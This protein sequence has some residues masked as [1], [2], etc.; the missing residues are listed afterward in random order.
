VALF[1]SIDVQAKLDLFLSVSARDDH[2]SGVSCRH[3][4]L[5]KDV[6]D[7]IHALGLQVVAWTVDDP[8]RAEELARMGVDGIT[9]HRVS[10]MRELL[11]AP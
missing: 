2:P 10:A 9:T 3:T 6:I 1:Y 11:G 7:R 5:D 8:R 4:L